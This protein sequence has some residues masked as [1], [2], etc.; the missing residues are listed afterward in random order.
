MAII[1]GDEGGQYYAFLRFYLW[2]QRHLAGASHP[3]VILELY[4]VKSTSVVYWVHST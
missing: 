3:Y 2:N 4:F 1:G